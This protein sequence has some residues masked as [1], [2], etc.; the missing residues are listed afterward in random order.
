MNSDFFR[1][2]YVT[3]NNTVEMGAFLESQQSFM[4]MLHEA[5][6]E[7]YPESKLQARVV[8]VTRGSFEIHLLLDLI[9]EVLPLAPLAVSPQG[10]EAV[11]SMLSFL[12]HFLQIKDALKGKKPESVNTV[13]DKVEIHGDNNVVITADKVVYHAYTN[14]RSLNS[15]AERGFTALKSDPKLERIEVTRA[16]EKLLEVEDESF[17]ALAAP[18][19]CL[20]P[21]PTQIEEVD[22]A[23][24]ITKAVLEPERKWKWGFIYRYRHINAMVTDE[25][26]NKR[27]GSG[28]YKFGAGDTLRVTLRITKE[29]DP[30]FR[31]YVEKFFEVVQVKEVRGRADQT[32]IPGI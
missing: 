15:A 12:K 29:Y 17:E 20:E 24:V 21:D 23:L 25:D 28:D 18:N 30:R 16:D 22:T 27:V 26:F 5:Q 9:E 19:E 3:P 11:K 4:C 7:L 32:S 31:T 13:G 8:A 6:R 14:N 10:V 1:F 2:D